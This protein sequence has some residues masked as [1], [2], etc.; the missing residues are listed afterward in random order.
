MCFSLGDKKSQAAIGP[1]LD[2]A[3][4]P[5]AYFIQENEKS[6]LVKGDTDKVFY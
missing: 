3:N 2:D 6:M 5:S 1:C 4:V